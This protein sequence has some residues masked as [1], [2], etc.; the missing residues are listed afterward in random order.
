MEDNGEANYMKVDHT[1]GIH[2]NFD[3]GQTSN[4]VFNNYHSLKM[5]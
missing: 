3:K 2:L 4:D 1:K 5:I